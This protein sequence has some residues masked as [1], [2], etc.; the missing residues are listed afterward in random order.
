[1]YLHVH[2]TCAFTQKKDIQRSRQQSGLLLLFSR[3]KG[4]QR[5]WPPAGQRDSSTFLQTRSLLVKTHFV[6][7]ATQPVMFIIRAELV[8]SPG[9]PCPEIPCALESQCATLPSSPRFSLFPPSPL[10][11]RR[12]GPLF[13]EPRR[14]VYTQCRTGLQH[15]RLPT[16]RA[17]QGLSP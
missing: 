2:S 5:E 6:V 11:L 3:A 12:P 17:A 13:W 15:L 4:G 14:S 7:G 9:F 10:S 16:E 8:Y 1:M